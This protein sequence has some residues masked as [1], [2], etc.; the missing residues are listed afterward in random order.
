MNSIQSKGHRIQTYEIH[1]SS[2]SCFN[3][4]I[5]IRKKGCDGLALGY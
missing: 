4:K 1:K 3:N 5:Y 2:L